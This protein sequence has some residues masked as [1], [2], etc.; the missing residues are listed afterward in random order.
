LFAFQEAV[1]LWEGNQRAKAGVVEAIHG[2]AAAALRAGDYDLGLSLLEGQDGQH[3]ELRRDLVQARDE[4][5]SRQRRLQTARRVGVALVA[6]I[7]AIVT[8]A[9][10]W[11]RS[12][13][14][15]ARRAELV[16]VN[17]RNTAIEER[18]KAD[19]AREQEQVQ[20]K[21]ADEA[22]VAAVHHKVLVFTVRK[23]WFAYGLPIKPRM[24]PVCS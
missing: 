18:K 2:Y 9:F 22:R 14:N 24:D 23:H 16:A 3:A 8:I 5:N 19:E 13:A 21:K 12:E 4:R 20:R 1:A 11:I 10:F 6:S 17:E 15:R 7:L